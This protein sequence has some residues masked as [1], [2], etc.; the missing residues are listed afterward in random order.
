MENTTGGGKCG[1]LAAKGVDKWVGMVDNQGKS[2][3]VAELADARDSKSRPGNRV[4]VRVPP[5]AVVSHIVCRM[6]YVVVEWRDYS[7]F[8]WFV[9]AFEAFI[10]EDDLPLGH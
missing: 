1:L 3:E 7:R 10:R 6:W 2:A 4:R 8:G 9:R 5:S